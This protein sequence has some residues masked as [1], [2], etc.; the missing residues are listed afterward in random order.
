MKK[1]RVHT[2]GHTGPH[3]FH[4]YETWTEGGY[5][6]VRYLGYDEDSISARPMLAR[7]PLVNVEVIIEDEAQDVKMDERD[8]STNSS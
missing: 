2:V 1:V 5:F 8:G 3:V 7:F 4:S 6:H